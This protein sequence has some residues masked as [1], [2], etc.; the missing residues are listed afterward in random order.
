MMTFSTYFKKIRAITV[1][2]KICGG[3]FYNFGLVGVSKKTDIT[4]YLAGQSVFG[5]S[6]HLCFGFLK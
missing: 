6:C 3:L 5:Y 1:S 2:R 4:Y